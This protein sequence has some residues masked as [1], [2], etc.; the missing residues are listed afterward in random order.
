MA[1]NYQVNAMIRFVNRMMARMIRCNIAPA[2]TYLLTVKGRK[3]GKE[4]SESL[5]TGSFDSDNI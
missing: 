1:K 5:L 2:G 3:T 4:Y